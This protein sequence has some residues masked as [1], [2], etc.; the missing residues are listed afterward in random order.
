M[1]TLILFLLFSFENDIYS[2]DL[3]KSKDTLLTQKEC[4]DKYQPVCGQP[5]MPPCR[6]E[7]TKC[8]QVM[9]RAKVYKNICEMKKVGSKLVEK[10]R[11][12]NF[13]LEKKTND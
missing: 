11:C 4:E 7:G 1:K 12:Q 6:H 5:P 8:I 13:K 2:K 10:S 9:P 3:Q